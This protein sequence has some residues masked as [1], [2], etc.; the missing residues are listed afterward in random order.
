MAN[1][2]CVCDCSC[3][4]TVQDLEKRLYAAEKQISM[5]TWKDQVTALS[6]I[7]S[8][9]DI[10]SEDE[11]LTGIWDSP[12][13]QTTWSDGTLESSVDSL[14]SSVDS[15]EV[16]EYKKFFSKPSSHCRINTDEASGLLDRAMQS[17]SRTMYQALKDNDP[18]TCFRLRWDTPAAV[19]WG[20]EEMRAAFYEYGLWRLLGGDRTSAKAMDLID[21]VFDARNS[22][23]HPNNPR[24]TKNMYTWLSSVQN[25]AS[26]LGNETEVE[27]IRLLKDEMAEGAQHTYDELVT[28]LSEASEPDQR[29]CSLPILRTVEDFCGVTVHHGM[30]PTLS[31]ISLLLGRL[32]LETKPSD[33]KFVVPW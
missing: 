3:A 17:A 6:D 24:T 1:S 13:S 20:R 32:E 10:E 21:K 22:W 31:Q 2:S 33:N 26:K 9:H 8:D 14:K 5:L 27:Y 11:A 18:E 4:Q 19:S 15:E 29:E 30:Q 28:L 25:L 7:S 23:A 12:E 16:T